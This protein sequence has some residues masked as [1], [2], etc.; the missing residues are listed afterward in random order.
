MASRDKNAKQALERLL[1][2]TVDNEMTVGLHKASSDGS[3]ISPQSPVSADLDSSKRCSR[4]RTAFTS[5]QIVHLEY[6]FNKNMYLSRLRR[7]EI[8][9]YLGLSEKQVKIWFQNRRVKQKKEVIVDNT[10]S[11]DTELKSGKKASGV[12]TCKCRCAHSV[13][14]GDSSG[15]RIGGDCDEGIV[16][17]STG[18]T[19]NT[20]A[21]NITAN[22]ANNGINS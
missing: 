9:H 10:G 20:M 5:T 6:E 2:V 14:D 22:S 12:Q 13:M 15:D 19:S 1:N 7:I 8:A 4:L 11:I 18:I 16:C 17:S 21:F 3:N